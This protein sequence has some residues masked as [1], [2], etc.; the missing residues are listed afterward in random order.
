[1]SNQLA[2]NIIFL[3][4]LYYLQGVISGLFQSLKLILS[5]LNVTYLNQGLFHAVLLPDTLKLLWAPFTDLFYWKRFGRRKTW[6]IPTQY[7]I[8]FILIF[9]ASHIQEII[10][11]QNK[12]KPLSVY[13]LVWVF[14]LLTFLVATQDMVVDAWGIGLLPK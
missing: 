3:L 10:F 5:E 2:S 4:L 8:A 6:L 7:I 1:M 13:P 9:S 11:H 14:S 12:S